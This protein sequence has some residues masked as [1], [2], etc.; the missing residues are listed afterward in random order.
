MRIDVGSRL[1]T[2]LLLVALKK[3]NTVNCV[4]LKHN[5]PHTSFNIGI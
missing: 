5:T 3:P 4:A 1:Y 2:G